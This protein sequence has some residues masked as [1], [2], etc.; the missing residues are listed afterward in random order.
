MEQVILR[1]EDELPL[2]PAVARALRRYATADERDRDAVVAEILSGWNAAL[3]C[4]GGRRCKPAY[5]PGVSHSTA[6]D[7]AAR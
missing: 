7:P 6:D 2:H 3:R 4:A 5:S 1:P